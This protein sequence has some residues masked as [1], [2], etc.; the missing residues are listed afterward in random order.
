[1]GSTT[2]R[3]KSL[4]QSLVEWLCGG[5]FIV[6]LFVIFAVLISTASTGC[7]S[8]SRT[9]TSPASTNA[10]HETSTQRPG[11]TIRNE[12][13]LE[14]TPPAPAGGTTDSQVQPRSTE[15]GQAGA[16]TVF[17]PATPAVYQMSD[18]GMGGNKVLSEGRSSPSLTPVAYNQRQPKPVEDAIRD[19]VE[20]GYGIKLE[21]VQTEEI[22]LATDTSSSMLDD[23]GPGLKTTSD[24]AAIGFD[25]SR[26]GASLPWGGESGKTKWGLD[27]SLF[28]RGLN[29]LMIIG[30]IVMIAAII[31][32][33]SP[34]RRWFAAGIVA[35]TGMLI[36]AAGVVSEQAPWVFV[37]AI[38]AFLGVA[39]WLGYEAWRNKRRQVAL[40]SI[41]KGVEDAD[42]VAKE[43]AKQS[44]GKAAAG[45][46][47]VVK[48]EVGATKAKV[49]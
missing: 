36:I 34:P 40:T 38:L 30:A 29:P 44:I 31:P 27:A 6:L 11:R 25:G 20:H 9:E 45:N 1:M 3:H 19:A 42:P 12:Y 35:L 13:K 48:S 16:L 23:R 37:L 24:E 41:V 8:T 43:I 22:P 14:M 7:A 32:V 18:L 2:S 39:G 28:T 49:T 5:A 46:L 10:T 4:V 17:S 47:A 15:A 33:I 26:S 21:H